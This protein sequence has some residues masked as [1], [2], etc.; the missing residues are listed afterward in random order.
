MPSF[1][2]IKEEDLVIVE[3]MSESGEIAARLD[4]LVIDVKGEKL[5]M[6]LE[7]FNNDK[8]VVVYYKFNRR[9]GSCTE[10]KLENKFRIS[11]FNAKKEKLKGVV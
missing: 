2:N 10:P 5:T 6:R 8:K 4:G 3:V 9:N 11:E 1:M 7:L